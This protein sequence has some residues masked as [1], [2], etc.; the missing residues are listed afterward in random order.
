MDMNPD[1][2]AVFDAAPPD[3]REGMVR[4]RA[5]ILEVA[6][7]LPQIG[8]LRETLRWAQPAYVTTK[9]AGASLR[10]GIPKTGGFALYTHCQTSVI[11]DFTAAFPMMD[12]VEGTRALHFKTA[13]QI[14]PARHGLLI[15]AILT[16]HL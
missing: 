16:Y 14:E 8:G 7:T 15:K 5:L 1:V 11:A 3:G 4:L 10:L 6:E 9:R 2:L 12:R 13:A